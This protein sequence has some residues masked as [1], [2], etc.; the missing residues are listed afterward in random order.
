MTRSELDED[1]HGVAVYNPDLLSR[2]E[3]KRY[4][5]G[6]LPLLE[7][8][9]ADLRRERPGRIGQHRLL[10][11]QRGMGKTSLLRRI[12]IAVEEDPELDAIWLPLTFPEEQYNVA[13]PSDLWLNCLDAIGDALERRG[14]TD[15]AEALDSRIESLHDASPE[16]VLNA[17][18]DQARQ[19]D[20]RLL[21]LLDNVD[22]ILDRLREHHWALREALQSCPELLLFGAS[23][24]AIEASYQYDAAFY[25]FFRIDELKGLTEDEL[26]TTLIRLAEVGGTPAVAELVER[27]PAR[28]QT[29]HLLTGGN[30][31]T[32][33]LLYG[34]LAQGPGGDV[35]SDLEG[36]LDRVTPLYKARFEEL[37]ERGQQLVDALAL[38]WD[39][40][41]ARQ[42]AD[43]LG[44]GVNLVSAQLDRLQVQ[45]VVEKT[46]PYQGKRALFQLAERFFNIWYLM[47]ASRRVRRRL[48]WLVRFLRMWF[49]TQELDAH[50][51]SQLA[52]RRANARDAEYSLA[53]AQCVEDAPLRSALENQGLRALLDDGETRRRL[54]ELLDLRGEDAALATKAERMRALAEIRERMTAALE[55]AEVDIDREV[56]LF[57]LLGSSSF[58]LSEKKQMTRN[59]G[60]WTPNQWRELS[61]NLDEERQ[62]GQAVLRIDMT[63][64]YQAIGE[65]DMATF[66]DIEGAA[67]A[68]E[69]LGTSDQ[70][71]VAW[72][73]HANQHPEESEQAYR[74]AIEIAPDYAY[75]WYGLGN[76]LTQHLARYDEAEQAFRRAIEI[77]PNFAYPWYGLGNLLTNHLAR[78]DEAE[79][80]YRRA[81]EI[82]PNFAD[83]WYGLGNLLKNHLARYDEAEQAYRRAI[84]IDPN[85]APPWNGL[86]NLLIQHLARYDEAEQAYRRAIEIDPN[87]AAPW[88]GLGNLLK[89]HLAR[90]D[91]AEQAYR[92]AIEI[93]PNNAPPWYGLGN[94]LQDHFAHYDEA[95]QAYRCSIEIDPDFA[96]PWNGLGNLLQDH[97]ARYDEAEQAFRRAIE[98]DPDFA[99]PWNGLGNLLK[100]HLARYDEAE[101]AYR[102]AIEIDPDEPAFSNALAWFLYQQDRD[103]LE[104]RR[105][106]ERAIELAP[107][108]LY[109]IHTLAT[110]LVSLGDWPAAAPLIQRLVDES[111][112]AFIEETWDDVLTLFQ[113][114]VRADQAAAARDLLD[115]TEAGERWRPLREALAA[116]AEGSADYLRLVAP[117]VRTPARAIFERLTAEPHPVRN[118]S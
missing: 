32:T 83:P 26:R 34:V 108:D 94:L 4:F 55:T 56:F 28:I 65:G 30:P 115:A 5:V 70:L 73:F 13:D 116:A 18:L 52:R 54:G 101:Q 51:R 93:D 100:N 69:R 71:A 21:L 1:L 2:D 97:L 104:A 39:P 72:M 109:S 40:A 60:G 98:I 103:L 86:G 10:L 44:W 85:N 3:L 62:K 96:H 110:I 24:R 27:D 77:E 88:N 43:R 76:L 68:A 91:E 20:R 106:A 31:R 45:G 112:T 75:P 35:R 42:L 58:S 25:D 113:E 29:L 84:E 15:E 79:Q 8:I 99:H 80:A 17:L 6:R 14:R 61:R 74:R 92:R 48:A 57:Q 23:A 12:A 114:A 111:S 38:H 50:A 22:L 67:A 46:A 9:L 87:N 49:S 105:R 78:Y 37:P 90:Y 63:A 41:S 102:R 16:T 59:A 89:N 33:V 47:R 53:L 107:E 66:D 117:E 95:E 7:R 82:D 81:I 19:L 11:G 36:L 64:L 118:A